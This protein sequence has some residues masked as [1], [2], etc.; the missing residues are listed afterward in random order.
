MSKEGLVL[1]PTVSITVVLQNIFFSHEKLNLRIADHSRS[2]RE[3]RLMAG[4]C[5]G[6]ER[7]S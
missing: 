1:A 6:N 5:V 7:D 3:K 4:P 2:A